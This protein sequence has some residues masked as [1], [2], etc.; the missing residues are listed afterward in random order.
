MTSR[1]ADR[2]TAAESAA[3][4]AAVP[5]SERS[6]DGTTASGATSPRAGGEGDRANSA[7]LVRGALAVLG[8]GVG[9]WG[10]RLLLQA[11]TGGALL[12]LPLWL[13]GAVVVDDL[14]LMPFT[15]A[16]GWL[17]T[18]WSTGP[19]RHRLVTTVRT[20]ILYAGI[21]TLVAI[22][23]LIRQGKGVNPTVL[24]RNYLLDWLLLEAT[25]LLT[26]TVVAVIQRRRLTFRRSR[27]SSGLIGGR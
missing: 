4:G 14:L 10:L 3:A 12:R 17:V 19:D 16:V 1:P 8:V 13:G 24:P 23:L 9:L 22:P 18:R 20:T 27:A 5:P 26:G 6:A 7:L 21:T 2:A 11:V 15:L 25:I